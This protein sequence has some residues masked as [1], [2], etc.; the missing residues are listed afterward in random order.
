MRTCVRQVM[1]RVF[2]V[3]VDGQSEKVVGMVSSM[4]LELENERPA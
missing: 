3:V 2:V 4:C 1:R